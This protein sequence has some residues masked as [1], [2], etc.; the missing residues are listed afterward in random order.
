[1]QILFFFWFLCNYE[2]FFAADGVELQALF[3]IESGLQLGD[4]IGL[5]K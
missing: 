1:M 4:L 2:L 5:K 3:Q